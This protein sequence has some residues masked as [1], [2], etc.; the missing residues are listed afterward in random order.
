MA[1][2][3][4]NTDLISTIYA[5]CAGETDRVT[6]LA[7]IA[8]ELSHVVDEFGWV[9][10]YSVVAPSVLKLGPYQSEHGCLM[11]PVDKGVCSAAAR[12]RQT[13]IVDDVHQFDGHI[14]CAAPIQSELVIPVFDRNQN[15]VAVLD[16]DSNQPTFF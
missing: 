14:N 16:I 6:L 11:I 1:K 9:V 8:G 10:F 15:L 4:L 2:P 12:N 7:V 5:I 3:R 13:Q